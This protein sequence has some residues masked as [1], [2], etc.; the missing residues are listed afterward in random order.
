MADP[1]RLLE[2]FADQPR[3]KPVEWPGP[4]ALRPGE[5]FTSPWAIHSPR[6]RVLVESLPV[7]PSSWVRAH[8]LGECLSRRRGWWTAG[9]LHWYVGRVGQVGFGGDLPVEAGEGAGIPAAPG[10]WQALCLRRPAVPWAAWAVVDALGLAQDGH[11]GEGLPRVQPDATGRTVGVFNG[12]TVA[13]GRT[14]PTVWVVRPGRGGPLVCVPGATLQEELLIATGKVL[15]V[16]SGRSPSSIAMRVVGSPPTALT[17]G[18]QQPPSTPD[19]D[20]W[21]GSPML[22]ELPFDRRSFP[23]VSR[24]T[25]SVSISVST[26]L[27]L[28]I[29]HAKRWLHAD[30][31][32]GTVALLGPPPVRWLRNLEHRRAEGYLDEHYYLKRAGWWRLAFEAGQGV[33][34]VERYRARRLARLTKRTHTSRVQKLVLGYMAKGGIPLGVEIS[35]SAQVLAT[36]LGMGRPDALVW[37]P[38]AKTLVWIEVETRPLHR[39]NVHKRNKFAMLQGVL[40]RLAGALGCNVELCLQEAGKVHRQ[41][42]G[43]DLARQAW[44]AG[45]RPRPE[46]ASPPDDGWVLEASD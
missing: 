33:G 28:E 40:P 16:Q 14:S 17:P 31:T 25:N 5:P 39:G 11:P 3:L 7:V 43:G 20:V 30:Y 22:P 18:Q 4:G 29:A 34:E 9:G 1:Q 2:G 24:Q 45:V 46:E 38:K 23:T 44:A 27:R 10:S 32:L 12:R 36:W 6:L 19:G 37:L 42:W 26:T 15:T 21:A 13:W 35:L 41:S 8:G